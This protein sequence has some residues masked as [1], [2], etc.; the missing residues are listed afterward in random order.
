MPSHFYE[1]R[2]L[3]LWLARAST[4]V[5]GP[6]EV[7]YRLPSLLASLTIVASVAWFVNWPRII[8][9]K[10]QTAMLIACTLPLD[11]GLRSGIGVPC[12]AAGLLAAGTV[13]ILKGGSGVRYA[14]A[15]LLGLSF[16]THEM[17]FFYI[18]IFCFTALAFEWRR[19]WK[20]V[21]VTVLISGGLFAIECVVYAILLNDPLARY[22]AAAEGIRIESNELFSV[23]GGSLLFYVWPIRILVFCKQWS[24]DLLL[25]VI[26][27]AFAWR[28]L[29]M[30]QKI[31]LVTM[32]VL[33]F[34][35]G[36][37]TVLPWKYQ[38]IHRGV[39]YYIPLTLGIAS[40][41]PYTLHL[42]L[43][44]RQRIAEGILVVLICF[45]VALLAASGTWGQNVDVSRELVR[46]AN[47]NST[48]RFLT[49]LRTLDE[50][51]LANRFQRPQNVVAVE[52]LNLEPSLDGQDPANGPALDRVTA[53]IDAIL[54]N[55]ERTHGPDARLQSLV[56]KFGGDRIRI[57]P[58]R[59]RLLFIPIVPLI[60]PRDF[61]IRSRGGE[62][63]LVRG[64]E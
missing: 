40:L 56:E 7:A 46:Y 50:M 36:Y 54:I 12:I 13:C 20:P 4:V 55:H 34:W 21:L 37:G 39:H 14:G 41:L 57:S 64:H 16:M 60:G 33:W 31:L 38:P 1:F 2:V 43:A 49:D 48:M 62:V 19:F 18:M 25:L 3:G 27:G 32:F 61:M 9:W 63:I 8:D 26:T 6:S 51:Q 52:E 35:L 5:F 10:S 30:D 29:N 24:F 45:H 28:R 58:V 44:G 42:A 59:Y 11:A 47:R 53:Q 23:P 22:H 17:S 15:A